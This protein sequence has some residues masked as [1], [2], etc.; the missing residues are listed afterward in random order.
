MLHSFAAVTLTQVQERK[1]S[2][3]SHLCVANGWEILHKQLPY[4]SHSV[5]T[6]GTLKLV[7]PLHQSAGGYY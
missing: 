6:L 2:F 3:S 5:H 1:L 7:F 4:R